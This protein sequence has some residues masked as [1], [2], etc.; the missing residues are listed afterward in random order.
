MWTTQIGFFFSFQ[1][2]CIIFRLKLVYLKRNSNK[3]LQTWTYGVY[4]VE[5]NTSQTMKIWKHTSKL[6]LWVEFCSEFFYG[7]WYWYTLKLNLIPFRSWN[8]FGRKSIQNMCFLYFFN[9][10]CIIAQNDCRDQNPFDQIVPY[11]IGKLL[12]CRCLKWVR[13]THLGSW[14]ISYG[15]KKGQ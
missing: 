2:Y 1:I 10:K 4:C 8:F 3:F 7:E 5:I 12:E 6:R 9:N 13:M 14:N 15:Q 11:I